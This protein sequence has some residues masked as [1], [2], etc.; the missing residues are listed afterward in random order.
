M[1]Q[2]QDISAGKKQPGI[3][4]LALAAGMIALGAFSLL[5]VEIAAGLIAGLALLIL[6]VRRPVWGLALLC[7][8]L[9]V[10][11]IYAGR[12]EMTEIRLIGIAA[13]GIWVVH[14]VI[15]G[16]KLQIDRPFSRIL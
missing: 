5:K 4:I 14:M 15:Y 11:G 13:F 9:T 16:R 12:L 8:L 2:P 1:T 10:E 6:A 7:T 3:V